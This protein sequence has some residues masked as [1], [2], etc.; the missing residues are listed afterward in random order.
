MC[1]EQPQQENALISAQN[2]GTIL[3]MVVWSLACLL[4]LAVVTRIIVR[5]RSGSHYRVPWTND[6][7]IFVTFLCALG[8]II[9]TSMAVMSGFG[10][11]GCLLSDGEVEQI[12]L[13]LYVS[14]LLFILVASISKIS[15][16]VFL[17]RLAG[18]A[19]RKASVIITSILAV[20]W[21]IVVLS[22]MVFQCELPTPWRIWTGKCIPLVPFWMTMNAVDTALEAAIFAHFACSIWWLRKSFRQKTLVLLLLSLRLILIAESVT[23]L[24]YLT[25]AYDRDAGPTY[26]SLPYHIATQCHIALVIFIVC[27][28]Y[29]KPFTNLQQ[30]RSD[31]L[32]PRS[33]LSRHWS[34]T[35]IGGTPYESEDPFTG[36][37]NVSKEPLPS[38]QASMY[39]PKTSI[40]T[41]TLPKP[42]ILLPDKPMPK[43]FV[44]PPPRPPPPRESLRPDMSLFVRTNGIR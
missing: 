44:K 39:M 12:Q 35:T 13:R 38:I 6:I 17:Y 15:A 32:T 22:G 34:S 23:R 40:A 37:M 5:Y 16:L 43:R 21:T 25:P 14:T 4:T 1:D 33:G 3:L 24:V 8:S 7:V 30:S 9:V 41:A 20:T 29:L 10:K 11:K 27:T 36:N 42:D 19:L 31:A 2:H 28:L 18:N 26:W